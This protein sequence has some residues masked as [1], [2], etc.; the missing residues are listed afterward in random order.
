MSSVP[1]RRH[2]KI[3]SDANPYDPYW[4]GYFEKRS[5]ESSAGCLTALYQCLSP[6]R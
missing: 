5:K 1:I 3:R 4:K 2:I 6:V